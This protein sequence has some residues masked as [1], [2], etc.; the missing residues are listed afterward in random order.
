MTTRQYNSKV[1]QSLRFAW[2][3]P[4][5]TDSGPCKKLG[6]VT[7][8]EKAWPGTVVRNRKIQILSKT[9]FLTHYTT[10]YSRMSSILLVNHRNY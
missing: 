4:K 10:L 3:D 7:G 1:Y 8:N 6:T 2:F 9:T 5:A